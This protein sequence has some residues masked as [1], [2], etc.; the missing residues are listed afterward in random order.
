M[1]LPGH[2]VRPG[3]EDRLGDEDRLAGGTLVRLQVLGPLRVWCDGV[4]MDPGPRQQAY[5]LA[6]LLARVGRPVSTSELM[7]LIWDDEVPSTALNVIQKYV[8]AL[9]RLLEPAVP[10]RTEGSYLHRRGNAYLFTTP[11]GT[12]DLVTFRELVETAKEALAQQ[13]LEMALDLYVESLGLWR[14]RAGDGF[15]HR[16]TALPIFAA[17]DEEFYAAC[18]EAAEVAVSLRRP[19][20]VLAALQLAA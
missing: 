19:A 11:P 12:L 2:S 14:G 15:T 6:L 8:G 16:S 1:A 17:I 9:R 4:E 7:D 10:A 18:T 20:R 3:N 13:R 5:L